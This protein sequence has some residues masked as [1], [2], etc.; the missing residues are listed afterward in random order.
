MRTLGTFLAVLQHAYLTYTAEPPIFP[1][2][3]PYGGPSGGST[4]DGAGTSGTRHDDANQ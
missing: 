1:F 2:P 3:S 4:Q